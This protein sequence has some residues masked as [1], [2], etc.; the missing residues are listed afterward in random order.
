[1]LDD[2]FD[3]YNRIYLLRVDQ[4]LFRF[5]CSVEWIVYNF[6]VNPKCRF[7]VFWLLLLRMG[8]RQV[9]TNFSYRRGCGCSWI[10]LFYSAFVCLYNPKWK[11][12]HLCSSHLTFRLISWRS[13]RLLAR[14]YFCIAQHVWLLTAF[15]VGGYYWI[16]FLLEHRTTPI[17]PKSDD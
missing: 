16:L 5:V 17:V 15:I 3:A 9:D 8:I 6:I 10:S 12:L 1:M 13:S 4:L 14:V 11:Q 7:F 2:T